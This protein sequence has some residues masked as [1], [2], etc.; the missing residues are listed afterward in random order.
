MTQA[1]VGDL[2]DPKD[3]AVKMG[4]IGATFGAAFTLGPVLGGLLSDFGLH[5]VGL[6]SAAVMAIDFLLIW[7]ILPEPSHHAWHAKKSES[8]LSVP[9]P[10]GELLPIYAVAFLVSF[11]FSGMQSTFAMILPDRFEL[12]A[13][14]VGIALGISGLASIAYQ[15]F[16]I[17]FVRKFLMEKGILIFGLLVMSLAFATFSINPFLVGAFAIPILFSVGFGSVNVST[18]ALISRVAPGHAGRAL[19]TNGSAMSLANIFGPIVAN[20][21]YALYAVSIYSFPKGFFTYAAATLFFL[22]ALPIAYFGISSR[23]PILVPK[24][25]DPRP[26]SGAQ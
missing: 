2:F 25:H 9:F 19:G 13:K 21:L 12:D 1:Y 16:L 4:A 10:W 23:H 24:R 14:S 11:G 8:D 6:V 15:G 7:L 5:V 3:R 26:T 17:R 20:F 18:S 22:C